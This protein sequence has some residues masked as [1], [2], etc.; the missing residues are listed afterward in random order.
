M[1]SKLIWIISL[2]IMVGLTI[3]YLWPVPR[4]AFEQLYAQADRSIV[5]ALVS[6][7][8]AHPPKQIQVDGMNWEYLVTGGGIGTIVFLHG[9]TGAYDIWW[10]QINAFE[11][12]FRIISV[13][14][15]PVQD[16]AGLEKGLIAILEKEGIQKFNLVGTSLG[17][18]FAQYLMGRHPERIQRAVLS[19]TFPPND[20]LAEKNRVLGSIVP[21][22]P[23]WLVISV[24]RGNFKKTIYPASGNDQF[25]LAFLN[26][27]SYGRMSKAQLV[28]RYYCVIEKFSV[29]TP[30][31]PILII[32][33][34]ND[35]LV[36][37]TLREQL[38]ATYP[39]AIVY[40]FSSAGHFPYLNRPQEYTD[41]LIDFFSQP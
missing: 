33:S 20:L 27:I 13:T 30:T 21:L 3:F 15:P 39:E 31:M 16:L 32:E 18:Y 37:L 6:F 1:C 24:F 34:D 28:G 5:Q 11:G 40:T 9:M 10:Q 2:F 38:K 26:E 22:M 19:N 8:N 23:E 7:R 35:P 17:G 12:Q 25:T 29:T 41:V 14:Y 36:E 4:V